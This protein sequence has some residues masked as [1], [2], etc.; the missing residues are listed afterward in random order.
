ML[1]LYRVVQTRGG[2]DAPPRTWLVL[3]E[4]AGDNA[5]VL[6]VASALGWHCETRRIVM[7]ERWRLGKPRVAASLAHVDLDRSDALAPPWPD[8]LIT[9]GRR[10]SSVAL[11]VQEQSRHATRLVLLGRPRRLAERFDLIVASAQYR[12][13]DQPNVLRLGLPLMRPDLEA[14]AAAA[15]A[16][17]PRLAAW[18]RPLTALLVGGPTKPVRFDPSVARDLATR[19]AALRD[20]GTLYTTTSRRTPAA[21][22]DALAAALPSGEPFFRWREGA[23]DN[24]Y[25]A[26]L[27]TADRFVVTSDS[28]TMLVEVARLGR[29]LA[30]YSLPPRGGAWWR[31][32]ASRRDLDA[33]PAL[34]IERGL[35]VRL[36]EPLR[37]VAEGV[38]DELDRVAARV[39]ALFPAQTTI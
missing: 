12:V 31:R 27:G 36:G 23:T 11:W 33:V 32:I 15:R 38:P 10:L 22:A 17:A 9:T 21:I 18:P 35:A 25:L 28:I 39:R 8:L 24:P 1:C 19:A 16:W 13:V 14:V 2:H 7:Q 37:A 4:K 20:G 26:L 5:Q 29:P 34:L 30:I 3:G 6:A